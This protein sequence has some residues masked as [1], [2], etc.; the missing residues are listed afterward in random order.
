MSYSKFT[1][2]LKIK[3]VGLNRKML[4]EIAAEKPQVFEKIVEFVK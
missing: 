1:G 2:A 3:E 4:S